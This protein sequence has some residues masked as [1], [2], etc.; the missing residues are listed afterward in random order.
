MRDFPRALGYATR[1]SELDAANP[2][3]WRLRAMA[4]GHLKNYAQAVQDASEGLKLYPRDK[5][6][7]NIKAFSQN[8]DKDYKGALETANAALA[9]DPN[10]ASAWMN[11]AFALAGM[12]DRAGMMEALGRAAALDPRYRQ[13]RDAAIQLPEAEDPVYL[14]LDDAKPAAKPGAGEIPRSWRLGVMGGSALLVLLGIL[15]ALGVFKKNEPA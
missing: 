12:G 7:L 14:F 3:A 5:Q 1:A 11:R 4:Q 9:V 8:K 10:D 2:D 15:G 6:L 13:V